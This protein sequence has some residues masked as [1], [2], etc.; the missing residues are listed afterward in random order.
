MN[1]N[2]IGLMVFLLENGEVQ[3]LRMKN[4]NTN[5]DLVKTAATLLRDCGLVACR[6][7]ETHKTK[8]L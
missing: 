4:V 8:V 7:T 6:T 1:R 5:Y 2:V 3:S